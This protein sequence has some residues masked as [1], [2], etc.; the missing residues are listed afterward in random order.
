MIYVIYK[1]ES[2]AAEYYLICSTFLNAN[3]VYTQKHLILVK[4]SMPLVSPVGEY[5]P[6]LWDYL[7]FLFNIE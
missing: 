4:S 7:F 6:Q 5:F 2:T 1:P 3:V